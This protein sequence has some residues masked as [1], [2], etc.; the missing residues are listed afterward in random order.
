MGAF[1]PPSEQLYYALIY[2]FCFQLEDTEEIIKVATSCWK[3][4]RSGRRLDVQRQMS[5]ESDV[6]RFVHERYL[7]SVPATGLDNK[8]KGGRPRPRGDECDSCPNK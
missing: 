3:A 1:A 7:D 5:L 6:N 4:T 8:Q 2:D